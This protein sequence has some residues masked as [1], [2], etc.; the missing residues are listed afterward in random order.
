M[1]FTRNEAAWLILFY[2]LVNAVWAYFYPHGIVV[3]FD[4]VTLL[5]LRW[6]AYT[7]GETE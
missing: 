1:A 4:L 3:V 2:G 7:Y 6:A 5:A